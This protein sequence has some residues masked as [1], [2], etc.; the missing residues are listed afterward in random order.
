[1]KAKLKNGV[2]VV[3]GAFALAGCAVDDAPRSGASRTGEVATT[4]GDRLVAPAT[5]PAGSAAKAPPDG[6]SA[7]EQSERARR[8]QVLL[9]QADQALER[10]DSQT[11]A[12][13]YQEV[14][15]L[16]AAN[17]RAAEGLRRAELGRQL[18]TQLVEVRQLSLTQPD[19]ALA[20]LDDI[21]AVDPAHAG[22]MQLRAS[23]DADQ[24]RRAQAAERGLADALKTPVS[25]QFVDQPISS[26]FSTISTM[27]KMNFVMDRDVPAGLRATVFAQDTS[28][29]EVVNLI[30]AS[31]RLDKKILND[32][33][34]LVYPKTP[35]KSREYKDLITRTFY[36]SNADPKAILTMLKQIVKSKDMY[37]DERLHS[38]M[39]RDTPEA[40]AVAERLIATQDL[41]EPEV[42]FDVQV[43]E[44]NNSNLLNLGIRYPSSVSATVTGTGA[45]PGS[46]TLDRLKNLN[47]SNVLLNLGDPT[48]TANFTRD[49]TEGLVLA[50][51]SI[52]VKNRDKAKIVIGDR[53]PVVTTTNS[54]GVVS[55]SIAYQD[56]GLTL[57]VEPTLSLEGEIGVKVSMEVSSVVDTIET[58][59]GLIAYQ[60]G[61]R[62]AETNMSAHDGETQVLAGL[63][64]RSEQTSGNAIPGLG[65]IPI[66]DRIFGSKQTNKIK[67]ELV[68]LI[69]PHVIRNLAVPARH[70]TRFNSGPEGAITT[71]PLFLHNGSSAASGIRQNNGRATVIDTT[72]ASVAIPAT[73]PLPQASGVHAAPAPNYPVPANVPLPADIEPN[74]STH[75]TE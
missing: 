58:N 28:V 7:F 27:A 39:I 32:H 3:A 72:P 36:L 33:T 30:L 46:L 29:E 17:P 37:V 66:L 74:N 67:T 19:K 5:S 21:Q 43:L 60:I 54:N 44:V 75:L 24:A 38:V 49:T 23:I 20:L 70:I 48:I 65:D 12:L 55:E 68:L 56:V 69:T 71:T 57:N 2:L 11:A 13:R 62:K 1:M 6:M 31:N 16:D 45:T 26:I 61:T 15:T 47:K 63:L 42:M 34:L 53:L 8:V 40:I 25:M 52:R 4:T 22:A 14:L 51:P 18:G 10:G 59:T 9:T 64:S 41:P 50:N 35:E 73:M